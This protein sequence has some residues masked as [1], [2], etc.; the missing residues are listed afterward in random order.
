MCPPEKPTADTP[1]ET[2]GYYPEDNPLYI[3]HVSWLHKISKI[4][5]GAR[6]YTY[7]KGIDPG[8]I[9]AI[10]SSGYFRE[11]RGGFRF[12][13]RYTSTSSSIYNGLF[14]EINTTDAYQDSLGTWITTYVPI[15]DKSG[16]IIG[17]MGMDVSISYV[18]EI[19]SQIRRGMLISFFSIYPI[20]LILI[21]LTFRANK[22][23][24]VNI[25]QENDD[26]TLNAP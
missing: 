23:L 4:L 12:C 26:I 9:I 13:E 24:M 10:G 20:L 2:N 11:P 1:K 25:K 3:A 16:N 19:K 6:V 17:A 5:P 21:L 8:E 18:E 7:I 14:G 15:Q 22:R